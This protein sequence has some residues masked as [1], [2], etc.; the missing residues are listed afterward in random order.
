MKYLNFSSFLLRIGL[1]FTFIYAA[2]GS[3]LEPNSWI[4]FFPVWLRNLAPENILLTGF[5]VYEL[6]LSAWLLSGY[7][8]LITSVLS[9]IT[10]FGVIIF[11][12]GAMDIIFRDVAILFAALALLFLN[13]ESKQS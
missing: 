13:L 11:N 1:A 7:K 5:S 4:G 6:V 12:L 3:F 10:I 9:A 8:I 2:V